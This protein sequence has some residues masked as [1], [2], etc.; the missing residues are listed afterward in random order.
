MGQLDGPPAAF[1]HEPI[2]GM[3]VIVHYFTHDSVVVV[4][5][6]FHDDCWLLVETAG[7]AK[8]LKIP[9]SSIKKV[10]TLRGN[11]VRI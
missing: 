5:Y 10:T 2:V 9:R 8:I 6:R 11:Q 1:L 3:T 4:E 7:N